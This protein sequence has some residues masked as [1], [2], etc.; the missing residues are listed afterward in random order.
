M[1]A[2]P[3]EL[4]IADKEP[5]RSFIAAVGSALGLFADLD[6]QAL[7][8]AVRLGVAELRSACGRLG[9]GIPHREG[10]DGDYAGVVMIEWPP[11]TGTGP[12]AAMIGRAASVF[13][14]V[15]GKQIKTC[16]GITVRVNMEELVT[17]DL[18][19]LAGA[20]G[21]P[22]LQGEPVLDGE[23]IRTGVFPFLVSEM[24]VR[25]R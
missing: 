25:E 11:A 22:I 8:E 14:A 3:V 12:Y 5:L 23:G 13:D 18:T 17:A 2:M 4:R 20:D 9:A 7:P 19:L 10:P 16:A 24:R 15:S 21:E 6:E 1:K